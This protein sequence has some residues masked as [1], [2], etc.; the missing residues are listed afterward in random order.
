MKQVTLKVQGR[1]HQQKSCVCS[2]NDIK[3]LMKV[4]I[5]KIHLIAIKLY[6]VVSRSTYVNA[7]ITATISIA[8]LRFQ[9]VKL[10]SEV[11]QDVY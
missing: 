5:Q 1:K 9:I 3:Y 4:L 8:F 11:L 7:F 6:A 10:F 2:L